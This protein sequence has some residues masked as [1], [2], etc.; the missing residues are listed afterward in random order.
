M[1]NLSILLPFRLNDPY[2]ISI[3]DDPST[4]KG[5]PSTNFL[6]RLANEQLVRLAG[7]EAI[8]PLK[9]H[10]EPSEP[11]SVL[12]HVEHVRPL[13]WGQCTRFVRTHALADD[14]RLSTPAHHR[15]P[16]IAMT[17]AQMP[18]TAKTP[19]QRT[20]SRLSL[21][22]F[23]VSMLHFAASHFAVI[24][25]HRFAQIR[26]ALTGSSKPVTFMSSTHNGARPHR[27]FSSTVHL[28]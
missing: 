6:A 1:L 18:P 14:Q 15:S 23:S 12:R 3:G 20:V 21:T 22:Q 4:I 7:L 2:V 19:T 26:Q 5:S 8:L 13:R 9:E 11:F 17:I 16:R 10:H 27:V 24:L 28:P 25:S